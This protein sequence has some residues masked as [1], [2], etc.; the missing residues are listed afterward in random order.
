MAPRLEASEKGGEESWAWARLDPEIRLALATQVDR[1]LAKRSVS[2][3]LVYFVVCVVL[4]FSTPYYHDYPA[5]LVS[6][7]ILTLVFGSLRLA[8]AR[9]LLTQHSV[10]PTTKLVFVSATYATFAY[11]GLFCAWT[12]HLYPGQ[13][14][15]MILLLSTA[16]FAGGGT[17]SLS[18]SLHL[19]FRALI[20][21][22]GPTVVSAILVGDSRHWALGGLAALYLFFLLSQT[23]DNWRSFWNASVAAE[24]ERLRSSANRR[25]AEQEKASLVAAIEQAAEE[26]L[27]TDTEGNIQYVNP[28]FE[29]VTGYSRSEVIGKNPRFLKSGSHD[30]AFYQDLW[31]TIQNGSVWTGRIT[32]RKKDGNIYQTEGTISPIHDS[33]GK[34]TGFVAARHDVTELLQL[35]SQLRQS[36]KMESIGRLAGG[37]AHDFNNLL[38]VISG[39]GD[40]LLKSLPVD[41]PKYRYLEGV[42]KATDRAA[43]LTQ[44]LLAF[45]RKQLIQ[46]RAVDLNALIIET[47]EMICRLLREDIDLVTQLDPSLGHIVMDP[48]QT[49][50]IFMNLAVNARDAMPGGGKLILRTSSVPAEEVP[51]VLKMSGMLARLSVIDTGAGMDEITR[52]HIFEPFF[53]TKAKGRGTGLGLSTVYGIVQQSGG[54]IEVESEVGKGTAF[55]LYFPCSPKQIPVVEIPKPAAVPAGGPETILLVEDLREIR[56]LVTQVLEAHGFHI[57]CACNGEEAL[58]QVEKYTGPIDLL[59]TDVIMPGMTGKQVADRLL[60]QR[61]GIK[62]LYMTGYSWEVIADRGVLGTDTPVLPKPFTPAA[63]L[64]KVRQVLEKG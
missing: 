56:T 36:Q 53:T 27:I 6:S 28:S 59:L 40:L 22:V 13:W 14:T 20:F 11:W 44:Q 58:E 30:A 34:L 21:L 16:S 47:R 4:A 43:N 15:S 41:D 32:N 54:W 5:T 45:S 51:V 10:D 2:A 9:R 8:S 55:H 46:P 17:S 50:H 62:V 33:S 1:E 25:K 52:Q 29:Q 31:H 35:E 42:R 57:L 63:L 26:I 12:L 64:A 3:S 24:R 61:P 48:E 60:A 18:P 49:I 23:R 37:V 39:Y 38:T 7:T 19:A